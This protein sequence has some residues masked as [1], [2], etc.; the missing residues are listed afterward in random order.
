M[1]TPIHSSSCRATPYLLIWLLLCAAFEAS[2][3][4][5]RDAVVARAYW[6]EPCTPVTVEQL[7][8]EQFRAFDGL[9]TR[10]YGRCATW[11]RLRID[12]SRVSFEHRGEPAH[13]SGQ[14]LP[15]A[16]PRTLVLRIQ[17]SFLDTVELF[18]ALQRGTPITGDRQSDDDPF[19]RA[20]ALHLTLPLGEAPR[21]V[22]LR[23][24]TSS[25]RL[26]LVQAMTLRDA[27][28]RDRLNEL[29]CAV[30][31]ALLGA[32]LL[33]AVVHWQ[34][35]RDPLV[36][37][38]VFK[39]AIAMLWSL[40]LLGYGRALVGGLLPAPWIDVS[41]SV[42]VI[43]FTAASIAF[44]RRLLREYDPPRW[45]PA[46]LLAFIAM[47]P[48]ELLL[49]ALGHGWLALGLNAAVATTAIGVLLA[50]ILLAR[51][52]VGRD[53]PVPSR[54]QLALFYGVIG[55]PVCSSMLTQ[56]GVVAGST[57][58]LYGLLFHGLLSGLIMVMMLAA[59]TRRLRQRQAQAEAELR[60]TRAVA[61][62]ERLHRNDREQLLNMLTHE[63]KTPL[64]V[65]RMLLG[66]GLSTEGQV[67][68][69]QRSLADIDQ[70]VERCA[71]AGQLDGR[72][73][74]AVAE[75]C[76]VRAELESLIA[77]WSAA[78]SRMLELEVCAAEPG[79]GQHGAQMCTDSQLL[80]MVLGNLLD[81]ACKYSAPGTP[82]RIRLFRGTHEGREQ[83][84][85]DIVNQP[86]AAG[87]P[88]PRRVFDKY[89]RSPGAHGQTGSGLGLYLSA[90]LAQLL[91]ARL[92]YLPTDSL[93]RLR[94][95]LPL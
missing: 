32:S 73:L 60:D 10:G 59:R 79:R 3:A 82:V 19:Y 58:S 76:D 18:D 28:A 30:Y 89:Y 87:W 43:G 80:R 4:D 1:S 49:M 48:V 90:G 81:N 91:G 71:Q 24:Q 65:M 93:V 70:V 14:H 29:L 15:D 11:L 6:D 21:D 45:G 40:L 62:Q 38:F 34:R 64:S 92:L 53:A 66:S 52:P 63:L 84:L 26:F 22:F 5:A 95:C 17:P 33:L 83:M 7:P 85:I 13:G 25:A 75:P 12:P 78:H 44:D 68:Q 69:M 23:V 77:E 50:S 2:A 41:T 54:A 61:R 36:G 20:L 94:L 51:P 72:R 88:D 8:L 56:L 16:G 9:L 46:A 74:R 67:R 39:Q 27:V 37:L 35:G 55:I 47:L 31:L 57:W 86:G 42:T